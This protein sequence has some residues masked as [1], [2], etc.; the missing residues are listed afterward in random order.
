MPKPDPVDRLRDSINSHD[1]RRVASCF[2]TD[3]RGETP[4]RP[5]GSF[6]GS[7]T[8]ARNWTAIFA[9]LPDLH[10]RVLRYAVAGPEIWTEWEITATDSPDAP[11][12]LCGPVIMTTRNGQVDWA[13]F[14]LAPVAP[15]PA[16]AAD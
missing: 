13:R 14:Y 2:T 8:V 16:H 1:P 10:A 9:R 12:L 15:S 3:Y 5:A 11:A 4:H 6:V 7:D